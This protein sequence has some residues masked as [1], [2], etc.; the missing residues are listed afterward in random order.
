MKETITF[1]GNYETC[2]DI[3]GKLDFPGLAIDEDNAVDYSERET[4]VDQA[5]IEEQLE[6]MDLT[7]KTVLHVGIGNSGLAKKFAPR[8]EW[9]DGLTVS[10]NEKSRAEQLD[11]SNYQVHL[12]SKY[13]RDFVSTLDRRYDFIV[14]NNL[15]SFACCKFHFYQMMDSYLW[16]LK[17]GGRILTDQRGMDWCLGQPGFVLSY[18][19]LVSFEK[20]FPVKA[21]KITDM[22]FALRSVRPEP[23]PRGNLDVFLIQENG[24]QKKMAKWVYG[25]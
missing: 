25:T 1:E 14:D 23:R 5:R 6:R 11:I 10:A 18:D 13:G 4:T 9:I 12:L 22:V 17:P 2:L 8:A 3:C 7:G 16:A 20:K 19:D 24:G 15:A 21:E